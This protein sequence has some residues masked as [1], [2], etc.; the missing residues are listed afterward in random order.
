MSDGDPVLPLG[1][2]S[3]P[4]PVPPPATPARPPGPGMMR[5]PPRK[6]PPSASRGPSKLKAYLVIGIIVSTIVLLGLIA[7]RLYVKLTA[8]KQGPSRNVAQEWEDAWQK[9]K[10]AQDEVFK[11]QVRVWNENKELDAQDLA[12]IKS[13]LT[14]Y[15]K[16]SDAFHDLNAVMVS[17]G[18]TNS[19]EHR[20]IGERLIVLKTWIWDANG[21]LDPASKPP[22][23]GGLFIPMYSAEKQRETASKR[24]KE[25]RDQSQEIIAR[26]QIEEIE[27]TVK[28]VKVLETRLQVLRDELLQL[29]DDLLKGL[30]LPD[31]R[32]E[33]LRELAE[34]REFQNL[35]Q[36]SFQEARNLRSMFPSAEQLAPPKD[37]APKEQPP[38][39]EPP[40]EEPPKEDPPKEQPP[41]E[42]PPKEQPK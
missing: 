3:P 1:V 4:D 2:P 12:K 5:P 40:K 14:T 38:K 10:K 7:W 21:V 20:D 26:R 17:K 9:S 28:E 23:Y 33:Q 39:E 15:Q 13:A 37:E 34:L 31:L 27:A 11:I 6:A 41:K 22:K 18:K 29:D 8:E 30:T 32:K 19:Q 36:M 42:D 25:I 16:T 24:M 35:A